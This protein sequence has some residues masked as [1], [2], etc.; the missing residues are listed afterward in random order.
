MITN[1]QEKY[2]K[3]HSSLLWIEGQTLFRQHFKA[4]VEST[5]IFR[6]W[7]PFKATL[8]LASMA[9]LSIVAHAHW[10]QLIYC[11]KHHLITVEDNIC[12]VLV[13][14]RIYALKGC[15]PISPGYFITHSTNPVEQQHT[16]TFWRMLFCTAWKLSNEK[17]DNYHLAFYCIM[18]IWKT[19]KGSREKTHCIKRIRRQN[20]TRKKKTCC[21]AISMVSIRY[22][23]EC[24]LLFFSRPASLN[25]DDS[26][27][28]TVA[29]G[30]F[31]F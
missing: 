5:T 6:L 12:I 24:S 22:V 2:S 25:T 3:E 8:P 20:K 1:Q 30:M 9:H 29:K 11:R 21:T 4:P 13:C 15:K 28:G 23:S 31:L 7:F 16:H 14:I 18:E 17:T 19:R 27:G 10:T 26:A